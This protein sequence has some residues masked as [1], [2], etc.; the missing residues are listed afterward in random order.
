[1]VTPVLS[2]PALTADKSL[3]LS[4]LWFPCLPHGSHDVGFMGGRGIKSKHSQPGQGAHQAGGTCAGLRRASAGLRNSPG[5]AAPA[6]SP[7][8]AAQTA[9]SQG[10]PAYSATVR[11]TIRD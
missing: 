8:A 5:W 10:A 3:P 11:D 7:A 6:G 1:M 2:L 4:A 9:G